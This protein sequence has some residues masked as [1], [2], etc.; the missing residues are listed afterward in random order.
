MNQQ[1]SI[2]FKWVYKA[3]YWTDFHRWNIRFLQNLVIKWTLLVT[4]SFN[5]KNSF[6]E[7]SL[8]RKLTFILEKGLRDKFY[9]LGVCA[10]SSPTLN[11]HERHKNKHR[12]IRAQSWKLESSGP[13]FCCGRVK[14]GD[15]PDI[16]CPAGYLPDTEFNIRPIPDILTRIRL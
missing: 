5:Y 12:N 7:D 14:S 15:G 11:K 8:Y 10:W 6:A 9:L 13:F 16:R 3:E 4:N 1:I 2:F